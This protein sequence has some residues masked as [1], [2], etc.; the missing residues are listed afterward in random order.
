MFK[1]AAPGAPLAV[2]ARLRPDVSVDMA[3]TVMPVVALTTSRPEV[4]AIEDGVLVGRAPG[5]AAVLIATRD[6][7]VVDFQHVWVAMPTAMVV[8]RAGGDEV[9]GPLQ[10][11]A[12]EQIVLASTMIAG[13]Q[14]LAGDGEPDWQVDGDA[15]AVSLLR[16]GATGR[17]RL[18]ARAPGHAQV[19][20]AALG[21]STTVDVEVVP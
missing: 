16:D 7:T 1:A 12:G 10:L 15:A 5:M 20:V 18:I 11:V 14:R 4:V 13:S 19:V 21:I 8:E 17:R 3:G 6:G 9:V 2:G